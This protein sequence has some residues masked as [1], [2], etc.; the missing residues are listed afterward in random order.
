MTIPYSH[1]AATARVFTLLRILFFRWDGSVWQLIR[2]ELILWAISYFTLNRIY[3]HIL[4][5]NRYF[6][7]YK[8]TI[9]SIC[10]ILK[11]SQQN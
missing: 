10:F 1:E 3:C 8:H 7:N 9:P 2:L 6:Y 5:R 11:F 4:V